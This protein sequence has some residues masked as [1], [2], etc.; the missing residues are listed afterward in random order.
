MDLKKTL[1]CLGKKFQGLLESGLF[2]LKKTSLNLGIEVLMSE[3]QQSGGLE[4]LRL[5]P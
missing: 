1:C 5:G 4:N 2:S 3:G